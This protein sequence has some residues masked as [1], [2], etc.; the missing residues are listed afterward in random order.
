V[1]GRTQTGRV[2]P[3]S[4]SAPPAPQWL[5]VCLT[6]RRQAGIFSEYIVTG[7]KPTAMM[8][9]KK[10]DKGVEAILAP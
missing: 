1:R 2:H 9:R 8:N 3:A 10:A 5:P 4:A 6:G 7:K